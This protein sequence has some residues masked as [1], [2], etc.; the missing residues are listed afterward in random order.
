MYKLSMETLSELKTKYHDYTY[1]QLLVLVASLGGELEMLRQKLFGRKSEKGNPFEGQTLLFNEAEDI[2]ASTPEAAA[3]DEDDMIDVK[4]HK[5]KRGKRKPLPI[6]LPRE[7][8]EYDLS[9]E[10]KI[11]SIHKIDL[12]KIGENVTEKLDIIPASIKVIAHVTFTYKCPCCSENGE[13]ENILSSEMTPSPIPKSFASAN[14]LAYIAVSKYQDGLPLYR[15]ESIFKRIDIDLGRATLSRWM[16]QTGNLAQPL[17]NLM[18]EDQL[19]SKVVGCDETP[20]QVLKEPNRRAEQKS[21]MWVTSTHEGPPI[22][23][24]EYS[25][26][27][28]AKV[29]KLLF[30]GYDGVIVCDGLKSYDSFA[31]T[32][33]S[34]IAGCMAHIRR[35]FYNAEKAAKK[36]NLKSNPKS[37]EARMFIKALY[38]IEREIKGKDPD[39]ILKVRQIKSKPIMDRFKIWLDRSSIQAL[40]QSLFGKA[41][42]YALGQWS[43]MLVFLEN[44]HVP[45]DNNQ[46]EGCIRPFVIG[47]NNWLFS[48]SQAGA[49]A[50]GAI[51]SLIESAKANKIDPFSYLAL[52]FKELPK[53]KLVEDFDRLLPHKIKA[54]YELKEYQRL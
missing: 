9:D 36:E 26:S 10:Q 5:K 13:K 8:V 17:L 29:V 46:T 12:V 33:N 19:L 1:D 11:C 50:S 39:L 27:R 7:R 25:Q 28:G 35:L 34:L 18:R 31:K 14:L 49:E 20:I 38:D 3:D 23:I 41:V 2:V 6:N 32:N 47:R 24:F 51:Y 21:F 40:P 54:H 16:I 15:L 44:P 48:C 30:E 45:I 22:I 52:I 37:T 43:K 53:A 42:N 4:G